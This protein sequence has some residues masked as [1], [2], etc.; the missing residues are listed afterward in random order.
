MSD[1]ID[2]FIRRA[3]ER[4]RQQGQGQG[5]RRAARP[6]QGQG[7]GQGKPSQRSRATRPNVVDAEVVSAEVVDDVARQLGRPLDSQGFD[8]RA[9][10]LGEETA[11]ADDRLE[12][13]LHQTFDHQLGRLQQTSTAAPQATARSATDV[14]ASVTTAAGNEM[15]AFLVGA[16]R[17]PQQ[18]RQAIILSDI[19]QRP[20]HRW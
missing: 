11:Q 2:D 8:Q 20:E 4:R 5:Q 3:A 1:E 9:A 18:V 19:L 13:R 12:A 10:Q 15:L 16:L 6:Q 14:A 17:S 7:Q